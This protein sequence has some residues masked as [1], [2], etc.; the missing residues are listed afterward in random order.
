MHFEKIYRGKIHERYIIVIHNN[1]HEGKEAA[2]RWRRVV[3]G[4]W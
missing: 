2:H 3:D 1:K 4:G